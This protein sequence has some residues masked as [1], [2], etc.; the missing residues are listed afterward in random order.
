MNE[1]T[2]LESISREAIQEAFRKTK[3]DVHL[4]IG[5]LTL[6][7]EDRYKEVLEKVQECFVLDEPIGK[8]VGIKW[9]PF[10]ESFWVKALKTGISL[11]VVNPEDN[12]IIGFRISEYSLRK[13]K[14]PDL[15]TLE[16]DS[17]KI[18]GAFLL[19]ASGKANIYDH[20]N[21]DEAVH[22]LGLGVTR[23]YRKRGF[24]TLL[25]ES[26]IKL[27]KN[28]GISPCYITGEGSSNF[29]KRIYERLGFDV[30][31]ETVYEDFEIEGKKVIQNT[32]EH[33]SMKIY[34]K[35]I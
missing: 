14:M 16:D 32:G 11:M 8:A 3:E 5:E 33:K 31:S 2:G 9:S 15:S 28:L 10:L 17:L 35:A 1:N 18:M 19:H 34:G 27:A 4:P 29:S 23:K 12:D 26:G 7:T 30:L 25:M 20:Y 22:F 6:I 24:G 13:E 21:T